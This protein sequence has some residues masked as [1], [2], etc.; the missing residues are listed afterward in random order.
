MEE[1]RTWL[2]REGLEIQEPKGI[3]EAL[4]AVNKNDGKTLIIY[5]RDC[6][7]NGNSLV[8]YTVCDKDMRI[9]RKFLRSSKE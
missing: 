7:Q 8:H 2:E 3:Y 6:T 4:R 1:F 5:R 9:I